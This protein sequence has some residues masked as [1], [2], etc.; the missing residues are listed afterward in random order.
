MWEAEFGEKLSPEDAAAE[1]TR[2]LEFFLV[3]VKSRLKQEL[4][5]VEKKLLP[6]QKAR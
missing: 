2:L 1:A 3:L 6:E 5:R 4:D